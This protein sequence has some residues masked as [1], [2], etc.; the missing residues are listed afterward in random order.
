MSDV[1]INPVLKHVKVLKISIGIFFCCCVLVCLSV[2]HS[3]V[4][5]ECLIIR[6]VDR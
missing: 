2:V 6:K 3:E 5:L 1:L 4:I